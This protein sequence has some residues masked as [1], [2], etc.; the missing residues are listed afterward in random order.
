MAAGADLDMIGRLSIE[1][2][3]MD[4]EV[5]PRFP[6]D[7]DPLKEAITESGAVL[8][9][10]DPIAST[11]GGADTNREADV[12]AA[13]DA[14]AKLAKDTGAVVMYVRHFGKG[15]GNASDK[16]T[17]SHA[18]RDAA[19]SVFLFAADDGR[20]VV[21]QDKGNYSPD[22]E[23]SFAFRLESVQVETSD[24]SVSMARVVELG[25][26][27]LTVEDIINREA[28]G[29]DDDPGER[30]AAVEWLEDYLLVEGPSVASEEVKAAAKKAG[31]STRTLQRAKNKL[32]VVYGSS[33]FP[34]KTTW[35]LPDDYESTSRARG[36]SPEAGTTG[37]TGPDQQK[38]NGTT[39][40]PTQG[41]GTTAT[42][43]GTTTSGD[44]TTGS[45]PETSGTT[46]STGAT[47]SDQQKQEETSGSD[48]QSRQLRRVV[49]S[50]ST[51]APEPDPDLL[52]PSCAVCA[53]PLWA[54]VSQA[55][56]VCGG[57]EKAART[58]PPPPLDPVDAFFAAA[59][60][61]EFWTPSSETQNPE[62]RS[63]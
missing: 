18:F 48:S 51:T 11:M 32:R 9:I 43:G 58:A 39:E 22:G 33:G 16:M 36:D 54:P 49:E 30:S 17:G 27:D 40:P 34:R 56:G 60:G 3:E 23:D 4:G 37:T 10:I 28:P 12:R 19:R 38:R 52:T 59:A 55:S 61:D 24:G 13:L 15:G 53:R 29:G 44:G 31:I 35:R 42:S 20:T 46:G 45:A 57:C 50:P 14:L 47:G 21:S 8:V 6:L 62:E 5:T 7:T 41:D 1:S 25:A 63:A 26:T 2:V